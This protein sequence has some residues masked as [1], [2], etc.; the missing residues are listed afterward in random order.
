MADPATSQTQPAP[1]PGAG[2]IF[3]SDGRTAIMRI[4]QMAAG[5]RLELTIA[6]VCTIVAANFQLLIPQ[7]LGSAVDQAHSLLAART[8]SH[9]QA[10]AALLTAGGLLLMAGVLRGLFTM[11]HGYLGEAIGQ[12]IGYKLRLAYFEKL[13]RLGF[14]YHDRIHSG[15][16]ITR[17]MLDIEGVRR[18][19]DGAMLRT[20]VLAILLAYGGYH[21]ISADPLLGVIALSFVPFVIWRMIVSRIWLRRTWRAL[22][23]RLSIL[24][25]VMEENLGGIRVVRAFAARDFELGKFDE[26]SRLAVAMS[27]ERIRIRYSNSAYMSFVYYIAMALVLWI[28]GH[29]VLT[30]EITVGKLAEFLAFMAILQQ[31]V[32]QV[33]MIV[34]SAARAS[35]SGAR[36]FEVLDTE[37][38][39]KD[40]A[41]ATPLALT[42]C[43]LR[44]DH[45]DF[46][47]QDPTGP[48]HAL[49]DI[50]FELAAGKTLGIVG[51]PGSGKS[52]IAQ[53]IPRFYDATGGRITIDDQDI[54]D[55]TLQS[56][57]QSVGLVQQDSFLFTDT[58]HSNVAY[59][60]PAADK[61]H[62][63]DATQSAQLH[64]Y[65][66]RLPETYETL[67]GERGITLSGGQRQR[68]S[69]ARS[70]LL[71]PGIII[72]DDSTASID[73]ATEQRIRA[74]LKDVTREQATIIISHRLSSLM[75]ADEILFIEAGRIVERGNH[76]SLIAQGGHYKA[77]YDL[78]VERP[79]NHQEAAPLRAAS[80][81]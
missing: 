19:I 59:G 61:D 63:I 15:D 78:Q 28:G 36:L 13:Q 24:T 77:L 27:M 5:Y 26:S 16:L 67:I 57:R 7:Y 74:A 3:S 34:N 55:V 8:T 21:L 52:S 1:Q 56:L 29:K 49:E 12:R 33:G 53:L 71:T 22:Q 58:I 35:I 32:R 2:E 48:I 44:F 73:A 39:I 9:T 80:N 70:I 43:R 20:I 54:R 38:V 45:V 4:L 30:G 11:A 10:Q 47:Y 72:F 6:I 75:H 42:G 18:F 23:E 62:I 37:P 41:G 50:T 25:R 51:P 79:E 64:E 31:P 46:A 17:G 65:I 60:E 40:A 66:A 68:L 81:A 14:D 76:Q 69:I